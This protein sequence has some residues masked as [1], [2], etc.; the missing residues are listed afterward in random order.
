MRRLAL[1]LAVTLFAAG[2]AM[3]QE[4]S[5]SNT[6]WN[7]GSASCG[8]FSCSAASHD[9]ANV[10]AQANLCLKRKLGFSGEG[11][12]AFIDRN[13]LDASNCLTSKDIPKS[14]IAMTV[15]PKC[16]V[17]TVSGDTCKIGCSLLG[18]K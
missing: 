8:S 5:T 16:C 9:V 17:V 7:F 1:I 2:P 3:A 14:T 6:G 10:S 4:V 15:K 18:T 11:G 13:G 12:N